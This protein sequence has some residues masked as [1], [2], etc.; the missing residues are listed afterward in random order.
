VGRR[1]RKLWSSVTARLRSIDRAT[2]RTIFFWVLVVGNVA[3]V[4]RALS[5]L[6]AGS[7]RGYAQPRTQFWIIGI[8]L[9]DYLDLAGDPQMFLGAASFALVTL[10]LEGMRRRSGRDTGGGAGRKF[11]RFFQFGAASPMLFAAAFPFIALA[12][13]VGMIVAIV[14]LL[15]LPIIAHLTRTRVD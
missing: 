2:R 9:G 14:G 10:T 5:L 8:N 15:V 12:I 13:F 11:L 1:L 7:P 3:V 4:L 6:S